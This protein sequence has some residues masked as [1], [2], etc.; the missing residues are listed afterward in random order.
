MRARFYAFLKYF[1]NCTDLSG[2]SSFSPLTVRIDLLEG[3]E[4]EL[5]LG[6]HC[7]VLNRIQLSMKRERKTVMR[8]TLVYDC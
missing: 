3:N 2:L 6:D 4:V 7:L 1:L 5:L 8:V